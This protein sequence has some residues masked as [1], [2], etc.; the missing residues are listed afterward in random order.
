MR[1][2]SPTLNADLVGLEI[3]GE[4]RALVLVRF[5]AGDPRR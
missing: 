5:I 4:K 1:R 3:A 2:H